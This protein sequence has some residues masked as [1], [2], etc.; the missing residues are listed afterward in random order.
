[1]L[2]SKIYLKM[3]KTDLTEITRRFRERSNPE[4]AIPMKKYLRNQFEI[5]GM[6]SAERRE[7]QKDIIKELGL[8]EVGELDE[9]VKDL[10]DMP[11][12]E[13]QYFAIELMFKMVKKLDESVLELVE[14]IVVRKSWWDSIDGIGPNIVGTYFKLHPEHIKKYT[15]RW[16]ESGNIWLQRICLLFQLK[17]KTDTDVELMFGFI[18]R[19]NTSKE[20]FI[21]KAIGWV[22]REYSKTDPKTVKDFIDNTSLSGLSVREGSKYVNR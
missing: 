20:F 17:Y 21:Q 19:L 14:Y 6:K 8:P 12:R 7:L 9:I 16:M 13:F 18:R 4:Y 22:L 10:W 1:M 5:I 3:K 2:I 15:E 11:E